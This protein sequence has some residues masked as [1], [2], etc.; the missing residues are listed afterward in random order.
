MFDSLSIM[1]GVLRRGEFWPGNIRNCRTAD[2]PVKGPNVRI[3]RIP[4]EIPCRGIQKMP[5]TLEPQPE[6]SEFS[7]ILMCDTAR[8]T[9]RGLGNQ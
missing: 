4:P 7:D 3:F 8:C 1:A 5:T 9:R 2:R 6:L